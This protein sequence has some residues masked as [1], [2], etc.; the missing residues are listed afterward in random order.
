MS[1]SVLP[2]GVFWV[3]GTW[4]NQSIIVSI[5]SIFILLEVLVCSTFEYFQRVVPYFEST[6]RL[7]QRQTTSKTTHS[8]YTPELLMMYLLSNLFMSYEFLIRQEKRIKWRSVARVADRLNRF[9]RV[10]NNQPSEY[11]VISVLNSRVV[12]YLLNRAIFD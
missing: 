5:I 12:L 4:G 7:V 2:A 10:Q 3:P 8:Y 1:Q 11:R 6:Y 9:L